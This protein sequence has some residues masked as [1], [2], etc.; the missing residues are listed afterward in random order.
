LASS[1]AVSFLTAKEKECSTSENVEVY[2]ICS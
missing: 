1:A 2:L